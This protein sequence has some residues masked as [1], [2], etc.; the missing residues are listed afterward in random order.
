MIRQ[1]SPAQLR[2]KFEN[3]AIFEEA[4][5]Q[6]RKKKHSR[7]GAV[8][9]TRALSAL[10]LGLGIRQRGYNIFA[11]GASGTGRSSTVH[12]L[13]NERAQKEPTPDD[14]VLLYNFEDRDRPLALFVPPSM[15]PKLK[16]TYDTL[17]ERAL[18]SLE[19]AFEAE[20]FLGLKQEIQDHCRTHTDEL[21]SS[22]ER[23]ASSEG[24]VLTRSNGALTLTPANENGTAI[25][26][27]EFERLGSTEKQALEQ[28]AEK[29]E[30]HLEDALRKVRNLEKD[31]DDE[32]D[33]LERKTA[34]T[35]LAPLFDAA[36]T[37]WKQ[38]D[39][40]TSHLEA[41]QNDMIG[42]LRRLVP[43]ERTSAQEQQEAQASFYRRRSDDED[44]FDHDE[45]S[46]LRYRVNPLV[47]RTK[48]SGAP[49]IQETHPTSS[50]LIGRI[51]QRVK[52]GETITDFTRIRAGALYRANGGYLVLEAQ[53]LL[54]D[55]SAWEGLKRALK[56]RAVELDDPGEPG[57]M[58]AVASL[59]PEPVALSLKVVLIGTPDLYYALSK[60]DPDFSKL[61]KVKADFETEV[62]R[63]DSKIA[64]YIQF[65]NGLCKDEH[66]LPLAFSGAS[67]VLEEAVRISGSQ[68]K[69]T[70]RLGDIADLMREANYWAQKSS[71][72]QIED[73]HVKRA[74]VA[75]SEREGFL[76]SHMH[77]DILNEKITI[78]TQG[79]VIGQCN[80]LTVIDLGTYEFG[81][82]MR[83]TC[84]VGAGRG[85]IIDVER[86]TELGGPIHTK[87]TLILRGI[88]L[89]RFGADVP[90]SLTAT[91]C[92]EQSYSDIDGDSASLAETC[93]LFS[94]LA[95]A[96]ISQHYAITGSIDQRGRIQ[97]VGGVNEKIEGFWRICK[98]R[99]HSHINGVILPASNVSDL[100]LK[101]EV[102]EDCKTGK[103]H[104]FSVD[105][106]EDALHILTG[107]PWNDGEK[108]LKPS[109]LDTLKRFHEIRPSKSFRKTLKKE[110]NTF[111]SLSNDA[112][113]EG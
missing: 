22:I 96:P 49:V 24:F 110:A 26:E 10:E 29:L 69:L 20:R 97:A 55:L 39:E 78:E 107:R 31:A 35:I 100:M 89:D 9:Q 30:S 58:V 99:A 21:F 7:L 71:D 81:V 109:I 111:S 113:L 63:S 43:D 47:T 48:N 1:L 87:G 37:Q 93:A 53:D 59:R 46:L 82:P 66:L 76:E 38:F 98:E 105:T 86:E 52:A 57:R 60:N 17:V 83:I 68:D 79:E 92:M 4:T 27:E 73:K 25:T 41:I 77:E 11:V 15:G 101:D 13:L 19:K 32:I 74:L 103:F 50:N 44:D 51:E 64:E 95:N 2:W 6:K 85:E 106:L 62:S 90:L 61:F 16:K 56:N 70:S 12:Q 18:A 23:E 28:S 94:G 42:R 102:V 5:K 3:T 34:E 88:L 40:I 8:A 75:K 91:L 45:P 36:K 104:I 14:T 33:K 65:M 84:R 67:Y 72:K 108:A 112:F 80:G 54:R